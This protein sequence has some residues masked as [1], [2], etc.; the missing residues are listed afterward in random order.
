MGELRQTAESA[1][2]DSSTLERAQRKIVESAR[3]SLK[4]ALLNTADLENMVRAKD[5]AREAGLDTNSAKSQIRDLAQ[6][7]LLKALD[8]HNLEKILR[9]RK[10]ARDAEVGVEILERANG[11]ILE[12]TKLLIRA[13]GDHDEY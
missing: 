5:V 2:V 3:A 9:A 4:A 1:G 6:T 10:V 7:A 11:T 13:C 12:L 8:G